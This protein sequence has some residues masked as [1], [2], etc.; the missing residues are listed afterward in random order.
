MT[1]IVASTDNKTT[2]VK[3]LKEDGFYGRPFSSTKLF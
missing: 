3:R 2:K 1:S